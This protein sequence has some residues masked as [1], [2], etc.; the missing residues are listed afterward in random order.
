MTSRVPKTAKVREAFEFLLERLDSPTRSAIRT[1]I[2]YEQD[3]LFLG[4]E[5][6][7]LDLPADIAHAKRSNR[8]GIHKGL[9]IA[10]GDLTVIERI[11]F[12]VEELGQLIQEMNEEGSPEA[13][14]G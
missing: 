13:D 9:E 2:E 1:V 4:L 5:P 12:K 10:L 7:M 6:G 14:V 11:Q 3:T 8:E